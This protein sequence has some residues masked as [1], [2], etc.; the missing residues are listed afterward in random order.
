MPSDR[1]RERE[2]A[3]DRG[4]D[5]V[6]S[7]NEDSNE[8]VWLGFIN[9]RHCRVCH[10]P[11]DKLAHATLWYYHTLETSPLSH[12][13]RYIN[14]VWLLIITPDPSLLLYLVATLLRNKRSSEQNSSHANKTNLIVKCHFKEEY[15]DEVDCSKDKKILYGLGWQ[16]RSKFARCT[17]RVLSRTVRMLALVLA[18]VIAF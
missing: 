18:R 13:P 2:R 7:G 6:R 11:W 8:P 17:N 16:I 9:D 1:E 14:F 5:R 4:R 12:I 10:G 3:G 15:V